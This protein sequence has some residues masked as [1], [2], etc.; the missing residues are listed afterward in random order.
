MKNQTVTNQIQIIKK[1]GKF[2]PLKM[3][4]FLVSFILRRH[5]RTVKGYNFSCTALVDQKLLK[6]PVAHALP[7]SWW[8]EKHLVNAKR[9]GL[10]LKLDLRDNLQRCIYFAGSYEFQTMKFIERNV[11]QN[12]VFI[13]VGAH[14]GIYSL[15]IANQLKN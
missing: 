15:V 6:E 8:L 11:R 4:R 1:I 3:I 2:L 10:N 12:D 7:I 5:S 14:I 9:L 13:D